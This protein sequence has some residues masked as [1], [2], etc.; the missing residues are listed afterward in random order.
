MVRFADSINI[1]P[2]EPRG[3]MPK[4]RDGRWECMEIE[5]RC[6]SRAAF[7]RWKRRFYELEGW[8]PQTGWPGRRTLEELGLHRV[9]SEFEARGNWEGVDDEAFGTVR[10]G[11]AV[12][13]LAGVFFE[14]RLTGYRLRTS[15]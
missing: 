13:D 2:C 6:L 12:Q 15:A 4:V 7:E 14:H 10:H 11:S 8:D 9:A 5:E 1:Q 3:Y